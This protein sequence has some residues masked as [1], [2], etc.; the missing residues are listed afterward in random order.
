MCKLLA[1]QSSQNG[2][3]AGMS[4]ILEVFPVS[5]NSYKLIV[6][7]NIMAQFNFGDRIKSI[8]GTTVVLVKPGT[9][10]GAF[11]LS[12]YLPANPRWNHRTELEINEESTKNIP[13]EGEIKFKNDIGNTTRATSST[14]R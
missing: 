5:G 12:P 6:P 11:I 14:T 7:N 4:S 8:S 9:Q 10:A 1:S 2:K 3:A 13:R